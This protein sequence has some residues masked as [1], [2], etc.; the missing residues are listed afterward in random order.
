MRE[1]IFSPVGA[2]LVSDETAAIQGPQALVPQPPPIGPPPSLYVEP[3]ITHVGDIVTVII[4]I[5]DK[6]TLGNSTGRSQTT[7]DGVTI[8][9]GFNNGSASSSS[10]QPAK[11]LGDLSSTSGTQGQGNIDRSEQI[12]VSVAAVVT[13]VLA[14]GNLVI[15][16]SQEVRVN[17]ELRQLTVAGIVHPSDISLNN[18]IAYDHIAEARISYGGRGRVNDFQQ[19]SWGQ[20]VYD[21]VRPF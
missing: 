21:A 4:S 18:T 2:G 14:N 3:R 5:N 1:P 6:A 12:Q 8:D 15:S 7:K 9:Y 16:G 11:I 19:P 20:Q 17:Y 10:N 13:R